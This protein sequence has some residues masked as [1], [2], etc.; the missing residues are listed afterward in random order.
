MSQNHEELPPVLFNAVADEWP[1]GC[2]QAHLQAQAKRVLQSHNYLS[3]ARAQ[4]QAAGGV[5]LHTAS[6]SMQAQSEVG[7]S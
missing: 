4:P 2:E 6:G 7:G 5:G 1:S 3:K